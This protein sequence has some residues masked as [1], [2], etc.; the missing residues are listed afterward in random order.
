MHRD[1]ARAEPD[2]AFGVGQALWRVF[3]AR[4]HIKLCARLGIDPNVCRRRSSTLVCE[5]L[6]TAHFLCLAQSQET[7]VVTAYAASQGCPHSGVA[8]LAPC[9]TRG[10]WLRRQSSGF[11][12]GPNFGGVRGSRALKVRSRWRGST[13]VIRKLCGVWPIL[14]RFSEGRRRRQLKLDR[15]ARSIVALNA[16]GQR[17]TGQKR[18]ICR[19]GHCD[20]PTATTRRCSCRNSP[21]CRSAPCGRWCVT[22]IRRQTFRTRRCATR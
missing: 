17:Q 16:P 6:L 12:G 18:G 5:S 21:T 20:A 22:R 8:L 13:V 11:R 9:W 4:S 7:R 1:L 14:G 10:G 19:Q 3:L 15:A 2:G